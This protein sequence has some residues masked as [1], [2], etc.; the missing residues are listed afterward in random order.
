MDA[1]EAAEAMWAGVI[2][3][4]LLSSAIGDDSF[5]RLAR[6]WRAMV[7]ATVPEHLLGHYYGVLERVA[8]QY[9]RVG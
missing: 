2:G 8:S 9:Q 3:C 4:H 1:A 6:T 5:A 7:R